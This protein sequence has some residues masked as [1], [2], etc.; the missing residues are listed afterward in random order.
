M[1]VYNKQFIFHIFR[2]LKAH[3]QAVICK[4]NGGLSNLIILPC[5]HEV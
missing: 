5:I 3:H 1:L 4:D 2:A